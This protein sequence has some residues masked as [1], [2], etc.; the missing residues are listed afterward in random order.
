MRE[1]L[2]NIQEELQNSSSLNYISDD[3]IIITE[4]ENYIPNASKVPLITIKD[5]GSSNDQQIGKKYRQT[6][7]VIINIYNRVLE[8]GKSLMDVNR[9]ILKIESDIF[10]ILIDNHLDICEITNSFPIIQES[11]KNIRIEKDIISYKRLIMEY[12]SYRRW[13]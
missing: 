11:T 5:Y 12:S 7:R 3:N 13:T 6:S 4:I 2:L 9:G 10:N 8:I 1:L